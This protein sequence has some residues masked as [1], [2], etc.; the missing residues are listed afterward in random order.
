M[1]GLDGTVALT[2][3]LWETMAKLPQLTKLVFDVR[4]GDFDEE[5]RNA[6]G[7]QPQFPASRFFAPLALATTLR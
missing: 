4:L 3:A 7:E 2:D 6:H 5:E 1:L